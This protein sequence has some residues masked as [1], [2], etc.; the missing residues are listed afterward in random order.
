[1]NLTISALD[2][3]H[4]GSLMTRKSAVSLGLVQRELELVIAFLLEVWLDERPPVDHVDLEVDDKS[5][6]SKATLVLRVDTEITA[7]SR[8]ELR[9]RL[10][11]PPKA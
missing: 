6:G 7:I 9:Q 4:F 10:D 5:T 1:M 3:G 11:L 8:A 2:R